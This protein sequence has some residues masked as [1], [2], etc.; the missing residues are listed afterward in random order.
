LSEINW[1][2][3]KERL[4]GDNQDTVGY[5]NGNFIWKS[6]GETIPN[7][8]LGEVMSLLSE[9]R[10]QAKQ[11][12]NISNLDIK[13][14]TELKTDSILQAIEKLGPIDENSSWENRKQYNLL[15]NKLKGVD[16]A[17]KDSTDFVIKN[18]V[19]SSK[20]DLQKLR[21]DYLASTKIDKTFNYIPTGR[22]WVDPDNPILP[23]P[24]D[25]VSR[26][27]R[28]R[29]L[30][31]ILYNTTFGLIPKGS[32]MGKTA[33]DASTNL[34]NY[35]HWWPGEMNDFVQSTFWN[36]LLGATEWKGSYETK[37]SDKTVPM[38][39]LGMEFNMDP[40]SLAHWLVTL[41]E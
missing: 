32:G 4:F 40:N 39:F 21:E 26:R 1:K 3:L 20:D 7:E 11:V 9:N 8:E 18:N 17:Y 10:L 30:D 25:E 23:I 41:D 6:T 19:I 36:K 29:E 14:L 27:K 34:L 33:A 28:G 31:E 38:N 37:K 15:V 35:M 5:V 13:S 2:D 12:E 24:I 22:P 16:K